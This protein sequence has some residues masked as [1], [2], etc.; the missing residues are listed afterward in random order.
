MIVIKNTFKRKAIL[1]ASIVILFLLVKVIH[2]NW[3]LKPLPEE[4]RNITTT[5]I[6]M[7]AD[8][9]DKVGRSPII[10]TYTKEEFDSF[11]E[12]ELKKIRNIVSGNIEGDAPTSEIEDGTGTIEISFE[13]VEE[14]DNFTVTGKI[15]PDNIPSIKIWAL[16]TL[17]SKEEPELISGEL[18]KGKTEGIY[19]CEI[20]RY[21]H[22]NEI[23][24]HE[25]DD[26]SMESM[27]IEVNYKI[28]GKDYISIFAINT[29]EYLFEPNISILEGTVITR[30]HDVPPNFGEDP[31]NDE[32]EYP[33]ILLLDNPIN[34]VAKET[35]TINSSISNISE[36]QLVLKGN[37]DVDMAKQ[38]KN[39]QIKVQGT[40]FSAFT[41]HH[42]TK[43]LM[44]VDDLSDLSNGG[45][46]TVRN[47]RKICRNITPN[48]WEE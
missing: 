41:G 24:S 32:E 31:D 34:I 39:K 1:L 4:K 21:F 48:L 11:S 6:K 15:V 13:M 36:I 27:F 26:F 2:I 40:L 7:I 8:I 42:H 22:G 5:N 43:V 17:N 20:N 45:N 23:Y 12:N 37:P 10:R 29:I 25:N 30:L 3:S 18:I 28:S 33:F 19:L 9:S 46:K 47:S 44:V 35:D 14:N 38:Y 16:S